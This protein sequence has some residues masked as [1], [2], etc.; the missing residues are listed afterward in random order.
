MTINVNIY[1]RLH[2]L[3]REA[4]IQCFYFDNNIEK[5]NN[6]W[7]INWT[8]ALGYFLS[9]FVPT[10][11]RPCIS[12]FLKGLV[13]LLYSHLVAVQQNCKQNRSCLPRVALRL[14]SHGRLN[15]GKT[16]NFSNT[17]NILVARPNYTTDGS[18]WG[19]SVYWWF[20]IILLPWPIIMT[21]NTATIYRPYMCTSTLIN[22]WKQA[23][24]TCL[25]GRCLL[26]SSPHSLASICSR[27]SSK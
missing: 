3:I 11:Y 19:W 18:P 27:T 24:S 22:S 20:L 9:H 2:A 6:K 16:S 12:I 13:C 17:A 7:I 8:A 5:N 26:Y 23:C 15:R 1:I 4:N 21:G 10:P 25:G 14:R